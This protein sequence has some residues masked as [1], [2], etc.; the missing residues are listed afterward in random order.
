MPNRGRDIAPKLI[1]FRD[2]HDRY[3]FVLHLHSKRSLHADFLAPWRRYIYETLLG[4]TAIIRSV[5]EAFAR[6]PQLGMLAP[7]HFEPTRRWLDWNGNFEVARA[8]AARMGIALRSDAALDFPSGSMFWARSAALRPVLDLNLSFEDFPRESGQQDHT[9]AHALERLYFHICERADYV[10]LKI[11]DPALLF[12]AR[13]VVSIGNPQDL[14]RFQSEHG[15]TLGSGLL[16]TR[17]EPAPLMVRTP[18]GL[19]QRL[20]Q[21]DLAQ[22]EAKSLELMA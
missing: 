8:L 19:L 7:Q 20:G 13:A 1:G 4:S 21:R 12:D 2:V 16:V 17:P 10:W 15:V 22:R 3:E 9:P 6:L 18:P 11:A 5:F 14:L